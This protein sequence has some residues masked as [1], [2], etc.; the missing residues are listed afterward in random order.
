MRPDDLLEFTRKRPFAAY[1]IYATD[2]QVYDVRHPDQVIVLR[3]RV[4]I[5]VGGA[6]GTPDHIEHLALIHIVRVEELE[7]ETSGAS[8]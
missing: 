3:S 8:G 5:G 1:R 2:G 7:P 4:V 6:N